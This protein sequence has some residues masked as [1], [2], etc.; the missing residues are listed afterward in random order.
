MTVSAFDFVLKL[1]DA[2]V[3]PDSPCYRPPSWPP[4]D[5]WV[6]S[7]S[8]N[9]E[10]VSRWPD[11]IWDLSFIV[12]YRFR[13][14]FSG[15]PHGTETLGTRN[16]RQLRLLTTWMIW[17][18]EGARAALT[19]KQQFLRIRRIVVVCEKNRI[20]AADLTRFPKVLEQ[21]ADLFKTRK[22]QSAVILL[23]DRLRRAR[24]TIGFELLDEEGISELA[25]TFA[26]AAAGDINYR[27]VEQTAYIPTRIWTYQLRRLRE[28]LDDFLQH[29]SQVE[30]CFAFCAD[31]Y[32]HNFGSL[33]NALR[34]GERHP[35][36]LPF[37]DERRDGSRTGR[38]NPGSFIET[39]ENFGIDT[40]LRKWVAPKTK[41]IDIKSLGAYLTLV[42]QLGMRTSLTLLSSEK[43]KLQASERTA[44]CGRTTHL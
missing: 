38:R 25:R 31:A 19:L 16:Q 8:A 1:E 5:D 32:A 44:C 12:G 11:S 40:L 39:A 28:C 27:K 23:L 3:A 43:K 20:L 30:E 26:D 17:G 14:H 35:K 4:P 9:G 36:L 29:K 7:E 41:E 34:K 6:V 10:P 18:Q 33:E 13:L 22:E 15:V 42:Q 21:V 24:G 37:S 2:N